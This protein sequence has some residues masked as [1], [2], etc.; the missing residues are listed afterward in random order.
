VGLFFFFLA[1]AQ[2]CVA[3]LLRP[4]FFSRWVFLIIELVVGYSG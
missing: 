1:R 4:F 3:V 2:A